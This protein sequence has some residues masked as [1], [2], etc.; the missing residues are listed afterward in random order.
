MR[1][2]SGFGLILCVTLVAGGAFASEDCVKIK[3]PDDRD[4]CFMEMA[5][6]TNSLE[7]CSKLKD[8]VQVSKNKEGGVC[9]SSSSMKSVCESQIAVLRK[10]VGICKSIKVDDVKDLCVRQVATMARD[11]ALCAALKDSAACLHDVASVLQ[12]PGACDGIKDETQKKAC[13]VDAQD[14]CRTGSS[15]NC[16]AIEGCSWINL[17]GM[18]K[19]HMACCPV[20]LE[21]KPGRCRVDID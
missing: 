19:A 13:K 5:I 20:K 15:R 11:K 3:I 2:L 6:K 14:Y 9:S 21:E 12:Q 7:A 4:R 16:D 8:V 18:E 17:G 1:R 10:D